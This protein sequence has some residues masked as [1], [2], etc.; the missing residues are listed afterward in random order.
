MRKLLQYVDRV[1]EDIKKVYHAVLSP[2]APVLFL[3]Q[4]HW[5]LEGS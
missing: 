4:L 2:Y 1:S 5:G 3:L